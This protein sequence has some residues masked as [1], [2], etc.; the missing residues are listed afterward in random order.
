MKRPVENLVIECFAE[1]IS[2][3]VGNIFVTEAWGVTAFSS[4]PCFPVSFFCL[5]LLPL[6]LTLPLFS[7]HLASHCL[8]S[9]SHFPSFAFYWP[10]FVL[11]LPPL[12]FL[13]ASPLLSTG[14]PSFFLCLP[15]AFSQPPLCLIL[16]FPLFF[17]L[18]PP[19]HP[20]LCYYHLWYKWCLKLFLVQQLFDVVTVRWSI[21]KSI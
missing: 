7:F 20:L 21:F 13:L 14:L 6:S 16:V 11:S 8:P 4:P 9:H 2:S 3:C 1:L 12:C 19:L 5:A 17:F 18:P 15:F 10:P